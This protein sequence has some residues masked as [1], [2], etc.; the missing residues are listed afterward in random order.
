M[1]QQQQQQMAQVDRVSG[2]VGD[3]EAWNG[4]RL[5]GLV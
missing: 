1:Q 3:A 5:I 2:A 4:R